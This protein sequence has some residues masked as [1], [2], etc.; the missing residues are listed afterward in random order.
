MF[1][2]QTE[3]QSS[4]PLR[5][6]LL[7]IE[8]AH[9][10]AHI[11][12]YLY[13]SICMYKY[14][15]ICICTYILGNIGKR[16]GNSSYRRHSTCSCCTPRTYICPRH[17]NRAGQSRHSRRQGV[18]CWSYVCMYICIYIYLYVCIHVYVFVLFLR[19]YLYIHT[20]L[21]A[22][23][24]AWPAGHMCVLLYICVFAYIFIQRICI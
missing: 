7:P 17:G 24:K 20:C 2:R 21:T 22:E 14:S 1:I 15:H 8:N 4:T 9:S 16:G 13:T 18:G 11:H 6:Y 3:Q 12:T 23:D 5:I 19:V 10:L